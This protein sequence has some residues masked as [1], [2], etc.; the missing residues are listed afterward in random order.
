MTK[1]FLPTA[2]TLSLFMGGCA[3]N[4][5]L[6]SQQSGFLNEY[7]SLKQS[8]YDPTTLLYIAQ[9]ADF[10]S[11][12]NVMVEPVKIIANN[13]QIKANKGLLKEMSE[14]MTQK[15]RN[16]IRQNPN[17][18]LVTKPQANT[19]KV[20][21]ALTAV[22][23]SHDDRE[24]YQYIPVAFVITE[25]ARASGASDKNARIVV[26]VRITDANSAKV[27][28]RAVSSQKGEQVAIDQE[29]KLTLDLL[30]P[31]LD[32]IAKRVNERLNEM[33]KKIKK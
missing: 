16:S 2:V 26:E 22:T 7:S 32:K 13:E 9:D 33:K 12:D 29:K 1:F 3:S 17:F 15:V 6:T 18:K 19:A 27:L 5:S 24:V 14:Y 4:K 21:F 25:A 31:A 8:P 20:E 11:Y 10:A 30:K 23:V 28:G